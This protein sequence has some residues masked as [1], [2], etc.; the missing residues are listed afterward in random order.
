MLMGANTSIR[1]QLKT[2]VARFNT[3]NWVGDIWMKGAG[4]QVSTEKHDGI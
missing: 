4:F 2:Q 3:N 1:S